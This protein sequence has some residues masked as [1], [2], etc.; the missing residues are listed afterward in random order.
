MYYT[1]MGLY[2]QY[3]EFQ[4]GYIIV[5]PETEEDYKYLRDLWQGKQNLELNGDIVRRADPK[6]TG[7]S[8]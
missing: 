6:E 2:P 7:G 4:P 3:M 1:V 8:V 5:H